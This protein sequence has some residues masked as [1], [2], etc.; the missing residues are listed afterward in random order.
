[1]RRLFCVSLGLVA[2][3]L[4]AC[5]LNPATV[6]PPTAVPAAATATAVPPSATPVVPATLTAVPASATPAASATASATPAPQATPTPDPNQ[7]VGATLYEDK[8]DGQ[9]WSWTFQDDVVNF[10]L[11]QNQLNAVMGRS[12]SFWRVSTGPDFARAGDQQ[13][14]V[15]VHTNLCYAQDEY[16]L[17][18]RN[19]STP[20]F[21]FNG[22]LF[23]VSCAGQVRV[24]ILKDSVPSVLMD[25]TAAPA[26]V[27]GAPADNTLL[28]WAAKD[29]LNFYVNGKYVGSA[30]DKT[31]AEG[32]MG[33]YVRD[34]TNGGLS[35]SFSALT[36]KEVK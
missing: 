25:W 10:S 4:T 7:G 12:D 2:G 29:K 22:Y 18:F 21:K 9:R 3:L 16:G 27:P 17:L 6:A 33:L 24:E 32:D 35:V 11:G 1:M 34:R 23:K 14:R 19:T 8:F 15:T 20:D 28:V 30:S 31:Y 36:I 5:Q 26:V 13:L